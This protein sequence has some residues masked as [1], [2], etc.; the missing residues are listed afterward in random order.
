MVHWY[1]PN[2][3]V[4]VYYQHLLA[5]PSDALVVSQFQDPSS[6]VRRHL[7]SARLMWETHQQ[8]HSLSYNDKKDFADEEKKP[9]RVQFVRGELHGYI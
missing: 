8:Q 6:L 1:W 4:F 7:M 5:Q 2:I 3:L 9:M